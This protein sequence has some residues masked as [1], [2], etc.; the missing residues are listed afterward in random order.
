MDHVKFTDLSDR[1]CPVC[2]STVGWNRDALFVR[3]D[4]NGHRADTQDWGKPPQGT[5]A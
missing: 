5:T 2:G 3:C 1:R 4:E